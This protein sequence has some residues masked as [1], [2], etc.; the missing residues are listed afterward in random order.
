MRLAQGAAAAVIE[1]HLLG[2]PGCR[3]IETELRANAAALARMR[4]EDLPRAVPFK[5]PAQPRW[6]ASPRFRWAAAAAAAVV[7]G[8]F[9][10]QVWRSQPVP[11]APQVRE[12]PLKIKM[13]TSDPRVVVYWLIE[14]KEES[15]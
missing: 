7:L 6:Y 15:E 2:C 13:L 12:A 5:I 8:V 3:A 14:T 11:P 4:D 1:E 9:A 10:P